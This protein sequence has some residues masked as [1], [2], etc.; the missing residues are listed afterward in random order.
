MGGQGPCAKMGEG[1]R[2]LQARGRGPGGGNGAPVPGA[3]RLKAKNPSGGDE[4]GRLKRGEGER[5]GDCN[6]PPF[7][8][9]NIGKIKKIWYS[10]SP[11][12]EDVSF[13]MRAN[14]LLKGLFRWETAKGGMLNHEM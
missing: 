8:N 13:P 2:F 14:L 10:A 12:N 11:G 4:E 5:H 6:S 1:F 9:K 3:H 7:V